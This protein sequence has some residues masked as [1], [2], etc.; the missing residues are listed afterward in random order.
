MEALPEEKGA[1][2]KRLW[3][4][5]NEKGFELSLEEVQELHERNSAWWVEKPCVVVVNYKC[6]ISPVRHVVEVKNPYDEDD[7]KK[8]Y[9]EEYHELDGDEFIYCPS[10]A[11]MFVCVRAA[12]MRGCC[13][14]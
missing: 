8:W 6:Y 12:E 13:G 2:I 9:Y 14:D 11:E 5:I 3:E 7:F 4:W 10:H 1:Y